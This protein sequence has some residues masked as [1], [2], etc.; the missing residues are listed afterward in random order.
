MRT[1]SRIA[2]TPV[3]GFALSHPSEVE[4]TERGVIENRRFFLVDGDGRRLRSSLTD[5][6]CRVRGVYDA[7][8]E[9]LRMRFPDGHEVAGDALDL[10]E[11][12][13][14]EFSGDIVATARVVLGP[15]GQ[16][17]SELAGHSVRVARTSQPGDLYAHTAS[18]VSEASVDRL[19]REAGTVVDE[20]R[21]RLLLTLSGC[22]PHEEDDWEGS[23]V[24][25]GEAAVQVD[26]PVAR[27]AATTR[28]PDSG[29]R[30]LDTLG[31]IR[32]YRGQAADGAI[33]FGM[34]ASVMRPG[35]VRVGDP[36]GPE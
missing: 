36:V 14:C 29:E 24:R 15:W 2:I 35:L 16:P 22:Q 30:D 10:G 11:E 21:F 28:H 26:G 18:L 27:C 4:L 5:W 33:C 31:L 6:P 12:V 25:V 19:A 23:S 32:R 9:A 3:K 20:R 7:A 8:A 1:V 13:V 17:L 34:L